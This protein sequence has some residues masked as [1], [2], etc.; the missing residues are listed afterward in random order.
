LFIILPTTPIALW[1][2]HGEEMVWRNILRIT[3]YLPLVLMFTTV[4]GFWP[5]STY[6]WK[7]AHFEL[8][9]QMRLPKLSTAKVSFGSAISS[10]RNARLWITAL[11]LL[12]S[13]WPQNLFVWM[14]DQVS[15]N[16]PRV[17]FVVDLMRPRYASEMFASHWRQ[18]QC[19]CGS[20]S[21][22]VENS[23]EPRSGART[24]RD[25]WDQI[26]MADL[27]ALLPDACAMD[28]MEKSWTILCHLIPVLRTVIPSWVGN[29]SDRE[30]Y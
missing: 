11:Q 10:L 6:R 30:I 19:C 7:F 25:L 5:I 23:F 17:R 4:P 13:I 26:P 29:C 14:L 8:L 22:C 27:P 28:S 9:P 2:L 20:H 18:P 12:N 1:R 15:D 3:I 24:S 16:F 21:G